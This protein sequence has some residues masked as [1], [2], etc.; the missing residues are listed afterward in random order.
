MK[1]IEMIML[2]M[3]MTNTKMIALHIL[4]LLQ[5]TQGYLADGQNEIILC[6]FSINN[7][8]LYAL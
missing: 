7:I 2:R 3:M 6:Y 4:C 8:H 5:S 1:M